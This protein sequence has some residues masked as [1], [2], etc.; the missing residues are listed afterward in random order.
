MV[1]ETDIER[2]QRLLTALE[3]QVDVERCILF[4]SRATGTF[5]AESDYD[6]ILISTDFQ[7]IPW[8][9][10]A[11]MVHTVWEEDAPLEVLC[12]TPDEFKEKKRHVGTVR[13]AVEEG[14][15][16]A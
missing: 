13:T 15:T 8:H 10:R 12:Y 2:V 3:E 9:R 16:V 5:A 7:G 6:L 11:Q 1:R 4:G 14:V